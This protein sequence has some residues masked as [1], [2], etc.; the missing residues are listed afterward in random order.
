MKKIAAPLVL[1]L[2]GLFAAAPA[3]AV[4][5]NC[6]WVRSV[7]GFNVI[8]DQTL[9]ISTGPSHTYRVNLF[10]HCPGIQW[11]ETIAIDSRDGQLCWPSNNHIIFFE[12]GIKNSCLVDSVLRMAP[13][14]IDKVKAER[15]AAK[16]KN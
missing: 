10:G 15:K 13:A 7:D 9:M 14:D 16:D 8:D 3:H 12:H 6:V 1:S 4:K 2:F 11:A 5:D